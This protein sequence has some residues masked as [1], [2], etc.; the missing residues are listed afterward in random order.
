[1]RLHSAP[2]VAEDEPD[3]SEAS[4][5]AVSESD[6][7]QASF[8]DESVASTSRSNTPPQQQQQQRAP[9]PASP[10]DAEQDYSTDTFESATPS[11]SEPQRAAGSVSVR[12]A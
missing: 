11:A 9:Q 4:A 12:P 6:Q 7:Q 5:A 2:P 1:L 8:H 3:T 10:A